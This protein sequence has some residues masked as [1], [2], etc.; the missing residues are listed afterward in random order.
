MKNALLGALAAAGMLAVPLMAQAQPVS[1][2]Y[3][4][5]GGGF[6]MV[7][8]SSKAFTY[9][10][11]INVSS[12]PYK[13]TYNSGYAISGAVGYGLGSGP[14]QGFRLELEGSYRSNPLNTLS[15]PNGQFSFSGNDQKTSA[16]LNLM[17]DFDIGLP[18]FPYV[19]AGAGVA[20]NSWSNV[21]TTNRHTT[22]GTTVTD[23][24]AR[25]STNDS[26]ATLAVQFTAGMAYP[27]ASVPGL[28]LTADYKFFALPNQRSF[29]DRATLTCGG[30]I[31]P[32][33][34]LVSSGYS[35]YNN[36]YNHSFLIGIRYA[37]GGP[38]AAPAPMAPTPAVV[39]ASPI[40]RS[41]LVFFDWDKA[42]L[43]DRARQIVAEAAAASGKV[44]VTKIEVNGYTD[45]SGTPTY[46]QGLSVARAK[47]VMAELV[48]D[49]V[50][51]SAIVIMGYGETHPLVPTGAN[52]RE[53]Q[54]R[55]VEIIIK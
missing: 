1:G 50:P 54:N 33:T 15:T 13:V 17:Y 6:N 31:C 51:A 21:T 27:I 41:Y 26:Q 37:F 30:A 10:P 35:T 39:P 55:R 20:L 46:N 42:V 25:E 47:V 5:L 53:P 7:E 12:G 32:S 4:S 23:E 48:R 36:E 28:S 52:V 24:I 18:I 19:G 16:I 14:F 43:T 3:V 8:D 49:G 40:A 38:T 29:N 22:F 11:G 44:Q 2:P 9:H 45:S 34:N